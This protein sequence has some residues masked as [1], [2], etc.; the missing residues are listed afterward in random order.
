MVGTAH[1]KK[2]FSLVT[3]LVVFLL[4]AIATTAFG[5]SQL[6]P[7]WLWDEDIAATKQGDELFNVEPWSYGVDCVD[8]YVSSGLSWCAQNTP[9]GKL[10]NST[11]IDGPKG[12]LKLDPFYG[13]VAPSIPNNSNTILTY[14]AP[15]AW[16]SG[17]VIQRSTYKAANLQYVERYG[18]PPI[19]EYKYVPDSPVSLLYANGELARVVPQSIT[20]SQ[21]GKFMAVGI[22]GGGI[23][24]YDTSNWNGKVISVDTRLKGFDLATKGANLAIS[25]DGQFVAVNANFGTG[26]APQPTL[27]VYD[28]RTCFDQSF[29]LS[30]RTKSNGCEFRDVWTGEF[31]AL[32][33]S[34]L[35]DAVQAE[36]PRQIRFSTNNAVL[37]KAVH[38]RTSPSAFAVS[39]HKVA[40]AFTESSNY[41]GLLGM[42]DSYISGEGAFSYRKP[43]DSRENKCHNSWLSYPYTKGNQHVVHPV[44]VACSGAKIDDMTTTDPEYIGQNN[45]NPRIEWQNRSFNERDK[46]EKTYTPGYQGQIVFSQEIRP[47]T[48]LLSVA[49]NDINFSNIVTGCVSNFPEETCYPYYKERRELMEQIRSQY[50]RLKNLYREVKENSKGNIYVVGYPEIAKPGGNCGVNVRLDA[51]EVKFS[52]DLVVYLNKVIKNAASDAGVL[53]VDNQKALYGNR[54]CE[55]PKGQAGMNGLTK[56][57]DKFLVVLGSE[58]YHPTA[59][60]YKMLGDGIVAKTNNFTTTMPNKTNLGAP[61]IS[62]NDP[63]LAGRKPSTI[64]YDRL[65]WSGVTTTTKVVVKSTKYAI[66][67]S[68]YRLN[69]S[70]IFKAI[71]KSEPV[72]LAEGVLQ[73]DGKIL[74]QTPNDIPA[75]FH[76]LHI[77]A[78]DADGVAVDIAEKIYIAHSKTDYNGDGVPNSEASCVFVPDSGIDEDADGLDDACD[79]VGAESF[80]P[81]V[82]VPDDSQEDFSALL[83]GATDANPTDSLITEYVEPKKDEPKVITPN[84]MQD[85]PSS[86]T[87]TSTTTNTT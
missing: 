68:K 48:I 13:F 83:G 52:S 7:D 45:I 41:V 67:V 16:F 58:S 62:D 26:A 28:T 19:K 34:A 29:Y 65:I 21:N 73:D 50:S 63:L 70:S 24:V 32:K 1:I 74:I 66:D 40:S 64:N 86:A 59:L 60:G 81:E 17:F 38:S 42:G 44:S 71:I 84:A 77:Y 4:S 56:G 2:F 27:R 87:S 72:I 6:Q 82:P 23:V 20:F 9:V 14:Y 18:L 3:L 85:A 8:T 33:Y 39:S 25:D 76:T 75:G 49:G 30:Q 12:T 54:L 61:A 5:A 37:F 43:T 35:K 10:A 31:R 55:A 11:L 51:E 80:V 22:D 53:Y 78:E 69:P 47:R 46:I 15:K 79:T 36:Y 57:N